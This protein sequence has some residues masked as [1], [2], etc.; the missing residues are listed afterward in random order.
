MPL[1]DGFIYLD[2]AA[3]TA[4]RPEALEAML[5]FFSQ[6][7]FNASSMYGSAQECRQALESSRQAVADVLRCKTTE[8]IFTSGGTES[9]NAAIKGAAMALREQG[10]HLVTTSVEHHAVL[11][12][13]NTLE[14]LGFEVTYLPVDR[15]GI[16][17]AGELEKA[18]TPETTVVSVMLANN[19]IGSIQPVR[20]L[21]AR[22]RAKAKTSGTQ[23]VFHTDAVQG[24]SYLDLNVEHLGVDMLSLSGHKFN[25]P[26][27]VGV[28]YLRRATPFE[29]QQVGGSHERNR[30]A[31][32]E[33]VP[34]IVGLAVA[35]RIAAEERETAARHCL[36]L[37]NRL[38]DGIQERIAH[39]RLNGHPTERLPN[40]VS[41][42]FEGADSQ[43]TMVALDEAG[44]AAST[45]SACHT[46]SLD[47]S[48]VLVATGVPANVALGT[49]RLTLGPEN[50]EK[51]V[52]RVLE[53][54]P[55]IVRRV[56]ETG[57][58]QA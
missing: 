32:T 8:V 35:L 22:V 20:E 13:C 34:G 36:V 14:Q 52:D 37:R 27:G 43:W 45:G 23:I 17:D 6:Q 46:A 41:F 19:E 50:A 7:Y 38:I 54:L 58:P 11:H 57:S 21:A 39:A 2:H 9:D 33:N 3:T 10:R 4:L 55:G 18:I 24:P 25:G 16:V 15:T 47:P 44:I 5:P 12:A 40:N 1:P 42:S 56:R 26:K 48:H 28:L 30:R 31:G 49:L 51:D 53:V 29:P